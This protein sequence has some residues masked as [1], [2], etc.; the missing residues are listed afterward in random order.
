MRFTRTVEISDEDLYLK[1]APK[2]QPGQWVRM[3]GTLCRWI[4]VSRAGVVWVVWPRSP[5][6]VKTMAEAFRRHGR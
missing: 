3:N 1:P 4:G 5:W 6:S 2:L